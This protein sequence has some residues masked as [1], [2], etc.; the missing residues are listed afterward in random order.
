MSRKKIK[1]KLNYYLYIGNSFLISKNIP[2]K[3]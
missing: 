3:L 2:I 1:F